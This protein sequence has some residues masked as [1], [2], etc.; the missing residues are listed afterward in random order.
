MGNNQHK[1]EEKTFYLKMVKTKIIEV[2]N[3]EKNMW[4]KINTKRE[5]KKENKKRIDYGHGSQYVP[6]SLLQTAYLLLE[7]STHEIHNLGPLEKTIS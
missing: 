4:M 7:P 2:T 5:R 1:N 3:A 6:E